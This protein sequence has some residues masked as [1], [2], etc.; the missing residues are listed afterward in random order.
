MKK[1]IVFDFDGTV[2][3]TLPICFYA[4]QQ[5]FR[6]FDARELTEEEIQAMFGPTE[7]GIIKQNLSNQ[8][9]ISNA[10]SHYYQS[11]Q[12][13]HT[14]YVHPFTQLHELLKDMK[15]SGYQIAIFTGKGRRSLDISLNQ[16]GLNGL[17]DLRVSG[18]DV[19][20]PKPNPQG[21]YIIM[22]ELGSQPQEMLMIGDS[23]ADIEAG[24][25]ANVQTVRVDWLSS[26]SSRSFQCQA[27]Y[28]FTEVKEL[29]GLLSVL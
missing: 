12:E 28:A 25:R 17:F 29:R 24:M 4:F 23:D 27:D 5:V 19:T 2:A 6:T 13:K 8:S 20:H 1:T 18:D 3:D 11:Y 26:V 7:V 16:L 10:I 9:Q 14:E 21:L 22:K 15:K